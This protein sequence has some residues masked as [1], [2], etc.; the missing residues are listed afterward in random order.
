MQNSIRTRPG[1]KPIPKL[2]Q[3]LETPPPVA[4]EPRELL[5]HFAGWKSR[6]AL[7][8]TLTL[9]L[10]L[11]LTLPLTLALNPGPHP[12][13]DAYPTC[14]TSSYLIS[15]ANKIPER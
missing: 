10:V 5:V 6:Y 2:D 15:L 12:D 11:T 13:P 7:A 14:N 8:L 3:V 1:P 4:G 9:T